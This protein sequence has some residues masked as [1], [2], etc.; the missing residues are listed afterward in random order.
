MNFYTPKNSLKKKKIE[1]IILDST[2]TT[3]G[4]LKSD[5]KLNCDKT[6]LKNDEKIKIEIILKNSKM[7]RKPEK[8]LER[9]LEKTEMKIIQ[10]ILIFVKYIEIIEHNLKFDK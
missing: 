8:K 4:L 5:V 10:E 6:I 2:D 3:K 1:F 9:K 7:K